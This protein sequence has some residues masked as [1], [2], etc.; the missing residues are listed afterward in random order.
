M[1]LLLC[2]L[3]EGRLHTGLQVRLQLLTDY[4]Q[5]SSFLQT[6]PEQTFLRLLV[7][8]LFQIAS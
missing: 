7:S 2:G 4:R 5:E 8:L 6:S 3:L 1:H